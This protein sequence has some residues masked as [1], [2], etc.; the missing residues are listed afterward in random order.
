MGIGYGDGD[1]T[2]DIVGPYNTLYART[3]FN[4][5]NFNDITKAI[6]DIDYDDGFVAYINGTEVARSGVVGNPPNYDDV[7][8]DHASLM[9]ICPNERSLS[10]RK[11][12]S[13]AFS[14][15]QNY[16]IINRT[17]IKGREKTA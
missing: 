9:K 17:K 1:D 3:N 4:L 12:R 14:S 13:K 10:V 2:T 5:T 16:G 8:T 15:F 7:A 6:L 11:E